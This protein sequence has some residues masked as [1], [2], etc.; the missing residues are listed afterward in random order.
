[1]TRKR[2]KYIQVEDGEWIEPAMRGYRDQ[3]CGCGLVHVTDFRV[4]EGRVQYRAW[5]D[6]RATAA[7]RRSRKGGV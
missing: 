5:Q 6:G 1:V 3:C 2:T 7:V 4:V